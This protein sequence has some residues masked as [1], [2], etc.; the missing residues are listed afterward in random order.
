MS[1]INTLQALNTLLKSK[2]SKR[3]RRE[4]AKQ[5]VGAFIRRTTKATP[6]V[7]PAT[8]A[9]VEDGRVKKTETET[10]REKNSSAL[11]AADKL[12]SEKNKRL[13]RDI[14]E[15]LRAQQEHRNPKLKR[16]ARLTYFDFEDEN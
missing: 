10:R 3:E 4:R 11:R 7:Q 16:K 5:N 9:L 6:T 1:D 13:Q 2:P 12:V 15:L 14:I 8:T